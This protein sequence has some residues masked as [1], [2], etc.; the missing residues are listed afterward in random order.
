MI[1]KTGVTFVIRLLKLVLV[2]Q[3][4]WFVTMKKLHLFLVI[5]HQIHGSIFGQITIS[6]NRNKRKGF[7]KLNRL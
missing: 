6:E 4:F 3:F 1:Y 7:L 5:Q 2:G